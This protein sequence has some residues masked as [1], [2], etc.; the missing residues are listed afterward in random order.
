MIF[1]HFNL[2]GFRKKISI[3]KL[4]IVKSVLCCNSPIKDGPGNTEDGQHT[5]YQTLK[6]SLVITRLSP[7]KRPAT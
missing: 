4:C 5:H 1:F 3:L 2:E 7:Q 6:I